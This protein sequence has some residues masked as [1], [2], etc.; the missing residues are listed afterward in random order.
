MTTYDPAG[1]GAQILVGGDHMRDA[2]ACEHGGEHAGA[3]ADIKG[4][5]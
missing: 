4:E 3:G 2:T 5:L 1:D